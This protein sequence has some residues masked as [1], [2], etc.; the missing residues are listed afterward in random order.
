MWKWTVHHLLAHMRR[1]QSGLELE[2]PMVFNSATHVTDA[3]A[4]SSCTT[5]ALSGAK[6]VYWSKG[7]QRA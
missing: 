3:G 5:I 7:R 6:E 1:E 2:V 4:L